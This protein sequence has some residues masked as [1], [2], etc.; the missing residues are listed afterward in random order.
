M[1]S[2]HERALSC[3]LDAHTGPPDSLVVLLHGSGGDSGSLRFLA[4]SWAE[5]LPGTAFLLPSSPVPEG[6]PFSQWYVL[7]P[8]TKELKG[9]EAPTADILGAVDTFQRKHAVP[10]DRVAFVG[11]SMGS[12]MAALLAL[13][14]SEKCMGLVLLSGGPPWKLLRLS[15]P[16]RRV[17]VLFC[18]GSRD[19]LVPL[20]RN[21][22][23]CEALQSMGLQVAF[24]EFPNAGHSISE[25]EAAFVGENLKRWLSLSGLGSKAETASV[26]ASP[27][28]AKQSQRRSLSIPRAS[29]QAVSRRTSYMP[30]Q[31][32][33]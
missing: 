31:R 32:G 28:S 13:Q 11:H 1:A 6:A 33:R 17:P 23:S 2:R 10:T 29:R 8:E 30:R 16:G 26:A 19:R 4:E 24:K 7:D 5:L 25:E 15:E 18:A 3:L 21:R 9:I 12:S 20:E 22:R 27:G 14:L